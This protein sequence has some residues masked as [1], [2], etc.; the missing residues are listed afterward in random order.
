MN[1]LLLDSE[2]LHEPIAADE[3]FVRTPGVHVTD[4]IAK[5]MAKVDP[6]TY[7]SEIPVQ[8]RGAYREA[9]FTWEELLSKHFAHRQRRRRE[10]EF[11]RPGEQQCDGLIGTPDWIGLDAFHIQGPFL[12]ESKFTWKSLVGF[13]LDSKKFLGWQLQMKAYCYM[14]GLRWAVLDTLFV[15]GG[16]TDMKPVRQVRHIHFDDRELK[17]NWTSLLNTAKKEGWL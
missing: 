15:N 14:M 7:G 3:D 5:I 12:L 11:V 4:C 2:V 10:P 8:H 13:D 6:E 1:V 9:G 17:D 16:Y